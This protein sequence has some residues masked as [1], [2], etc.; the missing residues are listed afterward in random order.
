MRLVVNVT[1]A[2]R[3]LLNDL[4]KCP[5]RKRAERLRAL[6]MV[7]LMTKSGSQTQLQ[8]VVEDRVVPSTTPGP[9]P[10][11]DAETAKRQQ[12]LKQSLI[13]SF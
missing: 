5:P 2:T 10:V 8:Q 12:K 9:E 13:G 11:A 6:A 1:E 3:E 7:G 4:E